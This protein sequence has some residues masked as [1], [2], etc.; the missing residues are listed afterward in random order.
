MTE[1]DKTQNETAESSEPAKK[2]AAPLPSLLQNYISYIGFSIVAASLISIVLLI[3]VE[4]S[5]GSDNPY[6]VLVTY[7]LLPS[8]LVF[9]ITVVILGLIL[10]RRRRRKNPDAG[11][12][13]YPILDLNDASRRRSLAFQT[14]VRSV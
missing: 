2:Q 8:V 14:S 11:L 12:P 13:K 3:L 7:I 1:E 5:K 4:F 9:G 6:T 10:E